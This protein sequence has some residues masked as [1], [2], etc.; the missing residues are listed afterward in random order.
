[1]QKT[2]SD[3][4]KSSPGGHVFSAPSFPTLTDN[5]LSFKEEPPLRT[6]IQPLLHIDFHIITSTHHFL[7]DNHTQSLQRGRSSLLPDTQRGLWLANN[8]L[9]IQLNNKQCLCMWEDLWRSVT[10]S[11][12]LNLTVQTPQ[13]KTQLLLFIVSTWHAHWRKWLVNVIC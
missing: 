13:W 8:V 3:H 4:S 10:P 5:V 6:V 7:A 1:M 9:L 2:L 12:T 11:N